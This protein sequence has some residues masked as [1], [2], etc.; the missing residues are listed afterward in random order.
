MLNGETGLVQLNDLE[1]FQIKTSH[2]LPSYLTLSVIC[3]FVWELKAG[4]SMRP[5]PESVL[6]N[7]AKSMARHKSC[8][9]TVCTRL[10]LIPSNGSFRLES[11]CTK[12]Q[13]TKSH[14]WL[15]T[16]LS[17]ESSKGWG[18]PT[19]ADSCAPLFSQGAPAWSPFLFQPACWPAWDLCES[20]YW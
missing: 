1:L 20:L 5:W 8:T 3:S 16:C 6:K 13:F 15:F 17:G 10:H 14:K 11:T 9:V 19:Q 18:H 12:W 7:H 2:R 4:F